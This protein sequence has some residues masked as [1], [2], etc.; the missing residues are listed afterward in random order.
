[1]SELFSLVKEEFSEE[2]NERW[3]TYSINFNFIFNN[4]VISKITITDHIWK[5][6]GRE[7]ITKEFILKLLSKMNGENLK[8]LKYDGDRDPY[9][10][11]VFYQNKPYVLF[12]WFKDRTTN[13]LWIRN[14]HRID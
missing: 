6:E 11:E 8:P 1:M 10:W 3:W 4:L 5:K 14:C 13:H 7:Q 2:F 9:E 12:F